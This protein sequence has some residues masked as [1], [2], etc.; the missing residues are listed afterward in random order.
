LEVKDIQRFF[1]AKVCENHY[2]EYKRTIPDWK[3]APDANAVRAV[4]AEFLKDVSAFANADGGWLI[5]GVVEEEGMPVDVPGISGLNP[6]RDVRRLEDV[7]RTGLEPRYAGV[8]VKS[9]DR[10]QDPPLL[11]LNVCRSLNA[12]HA[13]AE[14]YGFSFWRR[15][16]RKNELMDVPALRRAFV[17][18][19]LYAQESD[20]FRDTRVRIVTNGN[21]SPR[22]NICSGYLLLHVLPLGRLRE[23]IDVVRPP[24]EWS[25]HLKERFGSGPR[26]NRP[27][28]EGWLEWVPGDDISQHVQLFQNGGVEVGFALKQWRWQ[29]Q[30]ALYGCDLENEIMAW[31]QHS[32]RYMEST[33]IAPPY[34]IYLSLLGVLGLGLTNR[35]G[36]SIRS[37]F[38][39]PDVQLPS[40]ILDDTSGSIPERLRGF[41]SMMWHAAGWPNGSPQFD[42]AGSWSGRDSW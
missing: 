6:E 22:V 7:L 38:D 10:A 32:V 2:V 15:A 14:Q 35:R 18:G 25:A 19:E 16:N 36:E 13:V 23:R 29:E 40:F 9:I 17:E 28:L 31:A 41:V 30:Q 4:K 42:A 11:L 21:Q 27:N 3:N 5:Y 24:D 1:D 34:A 26:I 37:G 33:N 39:R 20:A 12:P 8:R